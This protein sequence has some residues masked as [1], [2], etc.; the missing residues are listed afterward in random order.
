[1][2]TL[3]MCLNESEIIHNDENTVENYVIIHNL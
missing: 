1:M 2:G 3:Q